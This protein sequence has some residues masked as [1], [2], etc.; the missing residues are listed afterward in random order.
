MYT[1]DLPKILLNFI[2][3]FLELEK[4][5][6]LTIENVKEIKNAFRSIK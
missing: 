3:N 4:K 6:F 2:K 5:D 1:I